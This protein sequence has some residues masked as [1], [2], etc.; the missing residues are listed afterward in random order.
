[1]T[2][3]SRE[4]LPKDFDYSGLEGPSEVQAINPLTELGK[5]AGRESLEALTNLLNLT[6]APR[7]S[8]EIYDI[9]APKKYQVPVTPLS[10]TSLLPSFL[11]PSKQDID[12]PIAH[13]LGSVASM[14]LPVTEGS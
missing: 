10:E 6:G 9:L 3:Y 2:V 13:A 8:K 1:M 11:M 7:A 5:F 4:S 12:F 14:A